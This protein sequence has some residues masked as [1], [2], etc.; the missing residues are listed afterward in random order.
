[1]I[2]Y[3]NSFHSFHSNS[4]PCWRA[5][6]KNIK[7]CTIC[8]GPTK[9]TLNEEYVVRFIFIFII[10]YQLYIIYGYEY[11]CPNFISYIM[12][13]W[14]VNNFRTSYA[15]VLTIVSF[16]MERYLAICHPLYSHTMSGFKRA[17]RIIG[18]V[19]FIAM[20]AALPYAFFTQVHYIDRPLKSGNI[21][22][23]SAFCAMLQDSIY[24]KVSQF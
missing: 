18:L 13:L 24:P 15:S 7:F 17:M 2:H 1:M 8:L 22:M 12:W 9:I 6:S 4:L 19:W 3:L 5:V 23:K 20:I 21:L 16:S 10:L 11:D 14:N